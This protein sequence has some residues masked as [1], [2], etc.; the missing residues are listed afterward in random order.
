MGCLCTDAEGESQIAIKSSDGSGKEQIITNSKKGYFYGPVWAPGS[1]KLAFSDNEKTL[2]YINIKE[3]NL[4]KVDQSKR[5]EIHD[6]QWS[7]DGLWITYNKIAENNF[8]DIYLYN[9]NDNKTVNISSEMND[10]YNLVFSS[11]GKYLFFISSRHENPVSSQIEFNMA[12][13]KIGGIYCI[14]AKI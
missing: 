12:T 6:Y 11:D 10:D 8:S 14:S 1:E 2:W 13:G 4:I 3:K 7:P 9:L 5:N